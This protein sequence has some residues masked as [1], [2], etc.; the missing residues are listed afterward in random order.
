VRA[1]GRL[2]AVSLTAWRRLS[3]V[4]VGFGI[5]G[6]VVALLA[7]VGLAVGVARVNGFADKFGGDVD[8]IARTLDRTSAVIDKAA[9]TANG[10]GA[11]IDGTTGA[12]GV[13]GG[14]IDSIVPRLQAIADQTAA[15]SIL[16]ANPLASVSGLFRD[17]A[18]QLGDVRGQ[19]TAI[20]TSLT[21]NRA[22]LA[23]N[24]S[25][26]SDLAAETTRLSDRLNGASINAAIGDVRLLLVIVLGIGALGAAVPAVGALVVGLWLRRA[27]AIDPA[28][29]ARS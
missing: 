6:L 18:T 2:P 4:L 26:L 22:A 27:L 24:A 20:G 7:L 3:R 10:F 12:L 5:V 15:I 1:D 19:L 11:T 21:T 28:D 29:D 9:T 17:I 13:V 16:G 8:G 23:A 14:D 25:S